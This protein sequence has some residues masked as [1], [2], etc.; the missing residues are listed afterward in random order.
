MN[1]EKTFSINVF[2][3]NSKEHAEIVKRDFYAD[4]F[5]TFLV[6]REILDVFQRRMIEYYLAGET[7]E[8]RTARAA[9]IEKEISQIPNEVW[10]VELLKCSD[11]SQCSGGQKCINGTCQDAL[12][13]R[14]RA[15]EA[16]AQ[17][18]ASEK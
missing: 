17:S 9:E 13:E 15:L 4:E 16:Y 12:A 5:K 8:E 18:A 11:D 14:A 7:V 1:L 6:L 10:R 2:N 3:K